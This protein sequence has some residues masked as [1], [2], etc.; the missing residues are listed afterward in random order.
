LLVTLLRWRAVRQAAF[1][2]GSNRLLAELAEMRCC[3][4]IDRTGRKGQPRMRWQIE[5]LDPTRHT[6]AQALGALPA[7]G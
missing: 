1:Q 7:F 2:G 4:L 5:Q 6:L 3:R